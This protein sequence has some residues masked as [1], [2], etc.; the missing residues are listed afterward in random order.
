MSAAPPPDTPPPPH[1]PHGGGRVGHRLHSAVIIAIIGVVILI[2][3]AVTA[4]IVLSGKAERSKPP[5]ILPGGHAAMAAAVGPGTA[6][7]PDPE[8]PVRTPVTMRL[9]LASAESI[10]IAE[11]I[12]VTAA[13]GWTLVN[14]GPNW[15]TLQNGDTSAQMYVA[16]KTTDETDVVA[17]LRTDIARLTDPSSGDLANPVLFKATTKTLESAKFQQA[18]LMDYFADVFTEQG[19]LSV[20]GAFA[21]LLN[22]STH[23]SAFID[24]RRTADAPSQAPDD[25]RAMI[26]SML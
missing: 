21:E 8:A 25:A 5:S 16:V 26:D 22:T 9:R 17:A 18:A 11:G 24:F 23:Q 10:D 12:S 1:Y 14:R 4:A 15:V 13:P 19:E 7:L 2:A 6:R 20:S 3:A